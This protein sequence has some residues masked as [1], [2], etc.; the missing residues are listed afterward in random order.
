MAE[1]PV[2]SAKD[3]IRVFQRLGF[4]L[5]RIRGSHHILKKPGHRYVLSV[6]VH[7]SEQLK[8]GTLRQLI[9]AA[10]ISVDEFRKL[11]QE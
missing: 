10:G 6:P 2:V 9:R 1:L 7:A 3:T 8:P 5:D 4:E 11:L